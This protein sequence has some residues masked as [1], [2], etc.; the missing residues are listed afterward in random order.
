[1]DRRK[2]KMF[3]GSSFYVTLPSDA[4]FN[5]FENTAS[6]WT[7]KLRNTVQLRGRWEVALVEMQYMNSFY[8]LSTSQFID[9]EIH[10]GAYR[11]T[12]KRPKQAKK[13]DAKETDPNLRAQADGGNQSATATGGDAKKATVTKGSGSSIAAEPEMEEISTVETSKIPY[14]IVVPPGHYTYAEQL[15]AA[16]QHQIPPVPEFFKKC[17]AEK[18]LGVPLNGKLFSLSTVGKTDHRLQF[19]AYWDLFKIIFPPGSLR[20]QKMLGF[21]EAVNDFTNGMIDRKLEKWASDQ[22]PDVTKQTLTGDRPVNVLMGNQSLFVYSDIADYSLI[23]DESAQ[24]LRTVPIKGN[25]MAV[26]NERFDV[27]HYVPVIK[28]NFDRIR[29]TIANDLGENA[30][31]A[32]GKSLVKL[33][34]RPLKPY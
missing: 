29:I 11:V 12:R 3:E 20:L 2:V 33:H 6:D 28:N 32:T 26:I 18:K 34:F 30:K 13:T 4:N 15:I 24:I 25:F 27:P 8:T 14:R 22:L 7:T 23:G 19:E 16:I 5:E 31:F 17:M 1:V 10:T 9:L 21:D